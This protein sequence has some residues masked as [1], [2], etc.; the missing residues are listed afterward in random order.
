LKGAKVVEDFLDFFLVGL[1]IALALAQ[2]TI[3]VARSMV[4]E[5]ALLRSLR[6]RSTISSAR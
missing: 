1:E 5:A 4:A 2:F 6:E 3:Y